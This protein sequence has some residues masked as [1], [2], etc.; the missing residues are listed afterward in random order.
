MFFC[1]DC[2][3]TG[4]IASAYPQYPNQTLRC[5]CRY[6]TYS[7]TTDDSIGAK[8][9]PFSDSER[10]SGEG[11]EKTILENPSYEAYRVAESETSKKFKR[12]EKCLGFGRY[13]DV[14]SV[15]HVCGE[16]ETGIKLKSEKDE[17]QCREIEAKIKELYLKAEKH[18]PLKTHI[19]GEELLLRLE[20]I[21]MKSLDTAKRKNTD[22]AG[23]GGN[24]DGFANLRMVETLTH[25]AISTE[26][27][28]I[29]RMT[30][31][32]SRV[33]SLVMSGKQPE[34]VDESLTDTL[35]DFGNYCYLMAIYR[36]AGE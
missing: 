29:T 4:F 1:D 13:K 21:M 28:F 17:A 36:G 30:D 8:I 23:Q 12:C 22:Y 7:R 19:S 10:L 33:I 32:F 24:S 27:G 9:L 34:V 3:N 14:A 35:I 20:K 15:E 16:C 25:G 26:H 11:M 6:G 2:H 31:K 5:V 18:K